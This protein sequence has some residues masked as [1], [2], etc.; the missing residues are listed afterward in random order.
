MTI[1][2]IL[3][4][5]NIYTLAEGSKRLG[6]LP[7]TLKHQCQQGKRNCYKIGNVWLIKV[8]KKKP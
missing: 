1:E 5:F 8:D 7:D 3:R 6:V 2:Q 4:K